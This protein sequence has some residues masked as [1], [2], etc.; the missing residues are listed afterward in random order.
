MPKYLFT[1]S[2][3]ATGAKGVQAEG[4]TSRAKALREAFASVGG[5]ME[6]Y[7]FAFGSDDFY[8]FGDLPDNTTA[9]GVALNTSA[10]GAVRTRTV[11]LLTPEEVDR[12]SGIKGT[13]RAPGA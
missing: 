10:T 2:F 12:A 4:G 8:V 9:A 3:T 11:V 1:G 7:Y 5:T 6:S 13:Y